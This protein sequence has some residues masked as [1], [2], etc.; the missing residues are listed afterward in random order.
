MKKGQE[1]RLQGKSI[2]EFSEDGK[3][4]KLVDVSG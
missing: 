4:I 1:L 2:F 3:I